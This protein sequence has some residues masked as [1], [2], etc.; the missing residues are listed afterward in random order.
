MLVRAARD[1]SAGPCGGTS[2]AEGLEGRRGFGR[3]PGIYLS[4]SGPATRACA[5]G[6][7]R[8]CA[9]EQ[10]RQGSGAQKPEIC[11]RARTDGAPSHSPKAKN[12]L[13][14][15][16]ILILSLTCGVKLPSGNAHFRQDARQAMRTSGKH[17]KHSG[18]MSTMVIWVFA[19]SL[20]A[21]FVQRVSG[22]GFGIIA[23]AVFTYL[24]P[25]YGE[26]TA[27]SGMLGA[28]TS[29]ITAIRL[30][31]EVPWKKLLPILLTFL[32]VSFFAVG[33]VSR[34]DS[35]PMKK[36]LG[37]VLICV[38]LYFFFLSERIRI[39]PGLG[40]QL[41]MGTLSGVMGGLFAMQGPPAVIYFISSAE[42]NREYIAMTQWYFFRAAAC[43]GIP[44]TSRRALNG[45]HPGRWRCQRRRGRH[46][47]Y[48]P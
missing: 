40:M 30:R 16:I 43:R 9:R 4:C 20:F 25:S 38:S 11:S 14:P 1:G 7:G 42:S 24:L 39:R 15:C 44:C 8:F 28:L 26:A 36:V 45:S 18:T 37:A 47:P 13:H 23:M 32:L 10:R 34:V 21:S 29:V 31:R 41:G 33:F 17:A 22:F 27:L 5:T 48:S 2:G 3:S 19:I 35:G 6:K 12:R 46:C